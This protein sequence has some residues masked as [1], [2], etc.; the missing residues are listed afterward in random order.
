MPLNSIE[1]GDIVAPV[2][3]PTVQQLWEHY[4][5]EAEKS[6]KDSYEIK[7]IYRRYFGPIKD[8]QAKDLS[9]QHVRKWHEAIRLQVSAENEG[10]TGIPS[11]NRGLRQLRTIFNY[12]LK[13]N[14]YKG[15]N[16]AS[17]VKQFPEKTKKRSLSKIEMK[18]FLDAIETLE[19]QR[20]KDFFYTVLFTGARCGEVLRMRWEHINFHERTWTVPQSDSKNK[21]EMVKHLD[22]AVLAALH[23]RSKS[24][25]AGWVFP[26]D[27]REKEM[28]FPRNDWEKVRAQF[29]ANMARKTKQ[30]LAFDEEIADFAAQHSPPSPLKAHNLRCTF[31][32]WE[33]RLGAPMEVVQAS[34]NHESIESTRQYYA[35]HDEE[36]V[37]HFVAS[38]VAAMLSAEEAS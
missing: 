20:S 18:P 17:L 37:K 34:M 23:R 31:A 26:G 7:A 3:N 24:Q 30:M 28:S 36:T 35:E 6:A 33:L 2:E 25:R 22:V 15:I 38:T 16:P 5:S 11:A 4:F 1:W 29:F 13:N 27:R 19:S 21:K 9:P 8:F 32:T 10:S 14:L 12:C